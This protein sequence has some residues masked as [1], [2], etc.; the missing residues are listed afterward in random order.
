MCNSRIEHLGCVGILSIIATGDLHGTHN[1]YKR[2]KDIELKNPLSKEDVVVFLGD[3]GFLWSIFKKEKEEL[4][5]LEYVNSKD[6]TI[7]WVDGNHENFYRLKTELTPIEKFGS[8]V[9]VLKEYPDSNFLHLKRGHIYNINDKK[10]LVLGGGRSVDKHNRKEGVSWWKEE[11]PSDDEFKL[12]FE[13]LNSNYYKVDYI[14][15]HEAPTSIVELML[16]KY[17]LFKYEPSKLELYLDSIKRDVEF[18]T[19]CFGHYHI[20]QQVTPKFVALLDNHFVLN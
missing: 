19:W 16:L 11:M 15:T 12:C 18:E 13:N 10:I 1:I 20:D 17:G 8:E 4:E 3:V 2:L 6:Y 14:F 9:G 5:F 7:A